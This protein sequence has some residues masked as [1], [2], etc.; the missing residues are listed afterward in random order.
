MK[1]RPNLQNLVVLLILLV[2]GVGMNYFK[3]NEFPQSK[4]AWA[5]ADR[6]A[7][8][9]GY[10]NNGM[11]LF[12]PETMV[13]NNQFPNNWNTEY[14]SSRTSTDIPLFEYCIAIL[15]KLFHS[16]SVWIFRCSTLL[17]SII[18]LLYLFKLFRIFGSD[19]STSIVLTVFAATSPL[20]IFYQVGFLPSISSL[21]LIFIGIYFY[22][23]YLKNG[24]QPDFIWA[25]LWLTLATITRT[26]YAI[27]LIAIVG[28]EF[29]RV[30]F[31]KKQIPKT[32][33]PI[34]ISLVL[35]LIL[36]YLKFVQTKEFGSVF[37][38]QPVPPKSL[39]HFFDL[40]LIAKQYWGKYYF[41]ES[42]YYL[43]VLMIV[44]F[45]YQWIA[46]KLKTPKIQFEVASY[47]AIYF[48][49]VFSF[50]FFNVETI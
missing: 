48:I 10:L 32:W 49:G 45:V 3:L 5:Q 9:V 41:S 6:Y 16:H 18:G 12:E 1:K 27:P 47:I 30:L 7:L 42:H 4:H 22:N 26:T 39:K 20:F 34:L 23:R 38:A 17:L 35:I 40:I 31:F 44:F 2:I 8:A 11:H 46:K 15:M 37:L 28:N 21:S 33:I 36:Q 43:Y 25:V 50:C 19:F 29:I 24:Q 13:M 14:T